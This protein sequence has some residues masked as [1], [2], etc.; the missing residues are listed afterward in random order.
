MIAPFV[1]AALAQGGSFTRVVVP[2][3]LVQQMYELLID[4]IGGLAN[5][6]VYFLPFSRESHSASRSL[7]EFEIRLKDVGAKAEFW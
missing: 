2:K 4:R 7:S 3:A 1:S 5:R 6:R